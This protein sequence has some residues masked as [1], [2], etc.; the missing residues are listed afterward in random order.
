MLDDPGGKR[1]MVYEPDET[2]AAHNDLWQLATA[3]RS[4]CYRAAVAAYKEARMDGLCE[5]GAWECA[6]DA[7]RS[8]DCKTV[9]TRTV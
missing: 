4:A 2:N 1:F 9:I 8:V 5:E 6:L 3:V 7:M